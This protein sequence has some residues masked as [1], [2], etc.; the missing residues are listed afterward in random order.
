MNNLAFKSAAALTAIGS[1][2]TAANSAQPNVVI[3]YIDDM[4][5]GDVGCYGGRFAPTPNIDK[6]AED[7]IKF[8][9]YY[10]AAP[11][12]SASR[13]GITTGNFPLKYGITTFLN[14]KAYNRN[15]G[16][17]DYLVSKAPS[18]GRA[19]QEA[20]YATAH[21]GKWHMGG[22]RDVTE[23]PQ[24]TE[25]GFD[26][27]LSTYESP[28]PDPAITATKWIW[29]KQ[30]SIKR[31]NRTAYF[32]DKSLDFI[33]RNPDKP[34]FLN[35]WPDDV[36]APWVPEYLENSTEKEKHTEEA[37]IPVLAE[38]DVQIGRFIEGLKTLGVEENTI[39]IF[40]SDNGPATN[41]FDVRRAAGLRGTKNSLYEGGINMPF[42]IKYPAKIEGGIVD[43]SSVLCSV[44]LYPSLCNMVGI[45]VEGSFDGDGEDRTKALLGVSKKARKG[46][47]MW[48]FGRNNY[49][50]KP[51]DKHQVSPHLAIRSGEWKLL[52]DY[53]GGVA[54]LYN[55]V[56]DRHETKDVAAQNPKIVKK[57]TKKVRTWFDENTE[58]WQKEAINN[59]K[60]TKKPI[61]N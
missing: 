49:Y 29:S 58:E 11:V 20:G 18:M 52:T 26:E 5:I 7:G 15:C 8:E 54:E 1:T 46:D 3:I 17:N 10:S 30:D 45:E 16:Q 48:D 60:T 24:I 36:H 28:D 43:E 39:V 35:L 53:N 22:G 12:S 56:E 32:V 23:A 13:C 42:I 6:L 61:Y 2:L 21:I 55:I 25:Y 50:N 47:L 9:Q 14:T 37:F 38:L 40:T 57:L 59:N 27:Y 33:A 41:S 51:D 4:G 34:F 19:F 44:D 31:W